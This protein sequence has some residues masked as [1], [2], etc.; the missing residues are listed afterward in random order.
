MR[1]V[2]LHRLI[3]LHGWIAERVLDNVVMKQYPTAVG[4][5][6]A[7]ARITKDNIVAQYWLSGEYQSEGS[8]ALA[9]CI[10]CIPASA[11]TEEVGTLVDA[12][13]LKADKMI[14]DTYA[15]RLL[16]V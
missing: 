14:A 12:F 10:D 16:K 5:K 8:N 11:P 15:A 2:V 4:P 3:S 13:A 1:E 6:Q 7:V 9:T